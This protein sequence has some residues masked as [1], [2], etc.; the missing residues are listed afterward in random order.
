MAMQHEE[1]IKQLSLL[2]SKY[3]EAKVDA[4]NNLSHKYVVNPPQVAEKKATPVRWLIVSLS[5]I[6]T[7]MFALF[8]LLIIDRLKALKKEL[9]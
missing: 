3:N 7:F 6:A 9:T 5:T 1:E 8:L 2:K 4:Y